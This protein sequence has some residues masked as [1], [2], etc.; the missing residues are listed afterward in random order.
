MLYESEL[1]SSL[2][3]VFAL[4]SLI[5]HSFLSFFCLFAV[6]FP[7]FA[8]LFFVFVFLGKAENK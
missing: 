7:F 1:V 3:P 4:R 2:R 5:L 8:V 6:R